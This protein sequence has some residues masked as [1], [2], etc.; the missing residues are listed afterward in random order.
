MLVIPVTKRASWR[1]PPWIT[2]S[3]ILINVFVFAFFQQNDDERWADATAFYFESGLAALETD[4]YRDYLETEGRTA[5]IEDAP[6]A[7]AAADEKQAYYYHRINQSAEFL[8]ELKQG[9]VIP[10][11]DPRLSKWRH[12]RGT[13]EQHMDRIV[14]VKYGFR[15]AMP[16]PL[17]W[18]T[19][20]F[21]HGGWGHLLG[22]MVFLWLVGC[23]IEYGCRHVVFPAIYLLG[24]L[25]ATG[26]FWLLNTQ[27]LIPLVGASG[28]IA[29]IMGAFTVFYGLKKVNIF[30]NLGVY[31]NY[32]K[33]PAFF[34]LPFWMANELYQMLYSEGRLVAY[35]AHLGGLGGGAVLAFAVGRI[36]GMLDREAFEAEEED[37]IGPLVEKAL[38]YMRE[39]KYDKARPLLE[40]ALAYAPEDTAV[41][42]HL[43]VIDGRNPSSGQF[44]QT[45]SR[46]LTLYCR[47]PDTCGDALE[48]F[49]DYRHIAN[50]PKLSPALYIRISNAFRDMGEPDE[51]ERILRMLVKKAPD[52]PGLPTGLLKLANAFKQ[53]NRPEK[54]RQCADLL[55]RHYPLSSERRL[56]L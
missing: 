25:A 27:S 29:G 19:S 26:F 13:Y 17:S 42:R 56:L 9:R 44:H 35:A 36:P 6:G 20:M 23:L 2:I 22:N 14:T 52:L 34:L 39:L 38:G 1:N 15:P 28:A 31:F 8:Q 49:R 12:L 46:L 50:P 47:Q 45:V 40:E 18:L 43:Y 11:S 33:F 48:L 5:E 55:N 4:L 41:W 32:L 54:Y 51:A 24:G 30:I 37:K 3:L 16:N 21:L 7:D 53:Q 10:E